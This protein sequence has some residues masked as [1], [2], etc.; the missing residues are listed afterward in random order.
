MH[1]DLD[2]ESFGN[3]YS[4]SSGPA[5]FF[6][7]AYRTDGDERWLEPAFGA[8]PWLMERLD[9]VASMQAGCGLFTGIA[10]WLV[11]L[12]ELADITEDTGVRRQVGLVADAIADRAPASAD[13]LNWDELTEI[14][15]GTAG[16]GCALLTLGSV[17]TYDRFVHTAARA[18]DWLLTQAVDAPERGSRW[19]LGEGYRRE[20]P[21]DTEPWYRR[22]NEAGF[23]EP[24][25][26]R[27]GVWPV[28][29]PGGIALMRS[30]YAEH[31]RSG[32]RWALIRY[33][34]GHG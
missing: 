14:T 11:L 10:G 18:G 19:P 20:R 27:T 12:T 25:A 29:R 8:V 16:T 28:G 31:W 13:W 32:G 24:H 6:V 2:D 26:C 4:G 22:Q 7:E 30:R 34:T 23:W 3:L 15:W 9:G 33:P 21:N 17:D 1:P 5:L